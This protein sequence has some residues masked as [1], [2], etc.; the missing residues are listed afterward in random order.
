M[1]QIPSDQRAVTAVR[2]TRAASPTAGLAQGGIAISNTPTVQAVDSVSPIASQLAQ[3]LSQAAGTVSQLGQQAELRRYR[4]SVRLADLAK[5]DDDARKEAEKRAKD[6]R[7]SMLKAQRGAGRGTLENQL[8][9][10]TDRTKSENAADLSRTLMSDVQDAKQLPAELESVIRGYL[11]DDIDPEVATELIQDF[12]P[13]FTNVIVARRREI[14]TDQEKAVANG[15]G[16]DNARP[17]A[18]PAEFWGSHT[19]FLG[20]ANYVGED[21][22]YKSIVKSPLAAHADAG[23]VDLV[24]AVVGL[25]PPKFKNDLLPLIDKAKTARQQI[26]EGQVRTIKDADG[27]A[28]VL[29]DATGNDAFSPRAR[30]AFYN[31]AII[32][33]PPLAGELIGSRD[34]LKNKIESDE[35]KYAEEATKRED[36]RSIAQQQFYIQQFA[37]DAVTNNDAAFFLQDQEVVRESDGNV[38]QTVSGKQLLKD[39]MQRQFAIIDSNP[40]VDQ[41]TKT[42]QKLQKSSQ[43]A[44]VDDSWSNTL[45][46]GHL[47]LTRVSAQNTGGEFTVPESTREA[48]RL[49]LAMRDTYQNAI[50]FSDDRERF[51]YD[52]VVANMLSP[53]VGGNENA[54]DAA[55]AKAAFD[56]FNP[57]DAT[58][59][60]Q[61]KEIGL[62]LAQEANFLP[63]IFLPIVNA[64]PFVELPATSSLNTNFSNQGTL[65]QAAARRITELRLA[66]HPNPEAEAERDLRTR[67]INVKGFGFIMEEPIPKV[68][69]MSPAQQLSKQI[70][71]LVELYG[72]VNRDAKG[73]P[74]KDIHVMPV[75]D[76]ISKNIYFIDYRTNSLVR[77]GSDDTGNDRFVAPL[78]VEELG[79]RSQNASELN[80]I[81]ASARSR[82]GAQAARQ[83]RMN[84]IAQQM[85]GNRDAFPR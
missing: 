75:Q 64:V 73:N 49:H 24:E 13:K 16:S 11:P 48:V 39:S 32:D 51:F 22:S 9:L 18:V 80:I 20:G 7:D 6:A 47:E 30:L 40:N 69:D 25:A 12:V 82:A 38:V 79:R 50:K 78:T 84:A 35:K 85:G 53:N 28:S 52:S 76:P 46:S 2:Q 68:G 56:S 70:D 55:I 10:F 63:N 8:V 26:L 23:N 1:S 67:L 54:L 74:M 83:Q 41:Q 59:S 57:I 19:T 29:Y 36:E 45:T 62:Q 72:D 61:A 71:A 58:L 66:R 81:A 44:Y 14:G 31:Q 77:T 4:E 3:V 17:T 65:E 42:R 5:M 27:R 33:N 43:L 60:D 21:D 34:A 15:I 37:A